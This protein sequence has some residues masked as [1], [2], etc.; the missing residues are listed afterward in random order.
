VERLKHV[1]AGISIV[2]VGLGLLLDHLATLILVDLLGSTAPAGPAGLLILAA[3]GATCT[4]FGG[5]AAARV[6]GRLELEHA[7]L[8]GVGGIVIGA[9]M[10]P[11]VGAAMPLWYTTAAFLLVLPAA[12][13]GGQIA[14]HGA[15][16][17]GK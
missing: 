8:V 2:A 7:A 16:V 17:D 3:L 12:L 4:V 1:L 14:R 11:S 13:L 5:Y 10:A 9:V 15:R 6:A